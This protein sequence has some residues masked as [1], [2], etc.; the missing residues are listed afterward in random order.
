MPSYKYCYIEFRLCDVKK[1]TYLISLKGRNR[2]IIYQQLVI[3]Y[4]VSLKL[5]KYLESQGI[6]QSHKQIIY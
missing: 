4:N 6:K 3:Y 1:I 2:I 5:C